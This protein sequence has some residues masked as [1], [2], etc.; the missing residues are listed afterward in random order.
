[1][2][3]RAT[4][5]TRGLSREE[6]AENLTGEVTLRLKD[7]SFGD[8]DPLGALARQARQGTLEPMRGP[9]AVRSATVTVGIRDRRLT[10]KSA[11]LELSGATLELNGTYPLGGALSLDVRADLQ[12]L[13]RRWLARDDEAKP[14]AP[15]AEVHLAG[16]LDKL[17]VIPQIPHT[18]E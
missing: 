1:M 9:V 18:G 3:A 16:P 5:K 4:V 11:P 6:L 7:L 10:V 12:H 14:S 15:F 17:V 13:R 2:N 8:F